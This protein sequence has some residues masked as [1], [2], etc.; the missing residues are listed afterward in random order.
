MS[1]TRKVITIVT[2]VFLLS[3]LASFG[4]QQI[5]IMPSFMELEKETAVKNAERALGAIDRELDQITPS[6]SDWAYWTD[7]Y[8]YVKGENPDYAEE[9]FDVGD[10]LAGL[11]MNFLAIY[12]IAGK[13][14]WSQALNLETEE[15]L[16]LEKLSATELPVNHPLLQHKNL[17]S[18]VKG[19]I[20]TS[21]AP[22]LVV[23]KPILTNDRKGPIA[24]T[25]V[26]GRFLDKAA[27]QRIGELTRLPITAKTAAVEIAKLQTISTNSTVPANPSEGIKHSDFKL[28]EA[29]SRWQVLS[30]ISD[31][32]GQPILTFQIDT[33]RNIS[34]QGARAVN[35]TQW[36]LAAT[37]MLMMLVLWKLLQYTILQPIAR[38]TEHALVI[39]KNDNLQERLDLQR[40]DEVGVLAR[41]FDQM[42][43]RLAET[44]RRLIDQSYHSGIAEMASGVL[45]NIG[46]AITPLNIRL[47]TLQQE[48][49]TAPLRE[50][51][52]AAAELADPA[53]TPDRRADLIQFVELAGAEMAGLI[54][55][56]QEKLATAILHLGQVQEILTDQQRFSR[57][58]RVIEPIDMAAVIKDAE[59]G[60]NP[61]LKDTLDIEITASAAEIGAVAGSRAAL[62]QVVANLLINAAESIQSA[63]IV[64]G[65]VTVTA[66]YEE[67]QGQTMVGFRFT[68][69]GS[70][71]DPEYYGRLFERGFSTKNR[72]GS[73]YGLHW[74]ANTIQALGGRISA[75]RD[76]IGRGACMHLLLPSAETLVQNSIGTAEVLDGLSN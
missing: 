62:Q 25:F 64:P 55:D 30:T 41:T 38:L 33:P 42:V 18:V 11:G 28:V 63:G 27:V 73:G 34:A 7:T 32:F 13:A 67:S 24:G 52:M 45:H 29:V 50:M 9:N 14:V 3:A 37:G 48:L 21:Y 56:S 15:T 46:N 31:I 72:E 39:G 51:E 58:A 20:N 61:E 17:E 40:E 44:R 74:S 49:K 47:S 8:D 71:I 57:S 6:V 54:R 19:I 36:I 60:L 22:L 59:A 68:D 76:G 70:G 16:E 1:L 12:D 66:E 2:I 26:L 53:T 75:E 5:F 4:I 35:Q 23:A 43:D 69:N 65:H 10:T